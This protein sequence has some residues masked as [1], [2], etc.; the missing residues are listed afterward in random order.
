MK[1][2]PEV[3]SVEPVIDRVFAFSEAQSAYEHLEAD[4]AVGKTVISIN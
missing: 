4:R 2:F 1:C 3:S